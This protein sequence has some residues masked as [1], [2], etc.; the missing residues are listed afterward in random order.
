MKRFLL[1]VPF[2]FT[3]NSNAKVLHA[4]GGAAVGYAVGKVG[5]NGNSTQN[6]TTN[7]SYN[8]NYVVFRCFCKEKIRFSDDHI[9]CDDANP[10]GT[11]TTTDILYFQKGNAPNVILG[12][13]KTKKYNTKGCEIVNN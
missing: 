8:G 3:V 1:I 6:T 10:D 11:H 5:S 9:Y 2:L 13:L 7:N 4:L 12:Q